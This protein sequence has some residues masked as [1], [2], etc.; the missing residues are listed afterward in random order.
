MRRRLRCV[1]L[2]LTLTLSVQWNAAGQWYVRE[3]LCSLFSC[4]SGAFLTHHE[5]VDP[6]V[7]GGARRLFHYR[8]GT[9]PAC[10]SGTKRGEGGNS[11]GYDG[12]R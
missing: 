10:G 3:P 9:T 2:T 6:V 8:Y 5:V 11:A 12:S 4:S 1:R 7:D